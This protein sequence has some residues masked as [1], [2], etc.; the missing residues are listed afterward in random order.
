MLTVEAGSVAEDGGVLV[1]EIEVNEAGEG[2]G[3]NESD[4]VAVGTVVSVSV[5]VSVGD[6][7]SDVVDVGDV[8]EELSGGPTRK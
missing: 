7:L 5:L 6:P 8:D 3:S 2:S 4:E 1:P